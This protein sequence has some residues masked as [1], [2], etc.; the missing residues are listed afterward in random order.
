MAK[1][2]LSGPV[3]V[4][5]PLDVLSEIEAVA[6]TCDRTRSWVIVRALRMYLEGEG[7]DILD[8]RKA[9]EQAETG[10]VHEM[11]DVLAEIREVVRGR[12]TG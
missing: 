3:P 7:A 6:E 8:Y 2:Q 4:R 5:L 9:L 10:D 12:A 1:D 11:D